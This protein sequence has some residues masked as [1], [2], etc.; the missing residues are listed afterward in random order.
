MER[1]VAP[2]DHT[3]PPIAVDEEASVMDVPGQMLRE[4]LAVIEGADGVVVTVTTVLADVALQDPEVTVTERVTE[5]VTV[6]DCVVAPFDQRL[7]VELLEVRITLPPGQNESGPLALI[8][9]VGME[10]FTVT[11]TAAEVAVE[12]LLVTFTV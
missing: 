4:P 1:V 7:P 8:V 5:V 12:P 10:V 2:L 9:G 11:T 3:Y 6:M